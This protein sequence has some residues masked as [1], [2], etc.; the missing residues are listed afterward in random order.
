MMKNGEIDYLVFATSLHAS[1]IMDVATSPGI[2]FLEL[3]PKQMAMLMKDII[4]S[5]ETVIP[6][7]MYPGIEKDFHT[8]ARYYLIYAHK[9]MPEEL[10]YR[11]TRV[12]WDNV[13]EIRTVGAFGKYIK[14]ETAFKG[15][16]VPMHPGAVR[17]YKEI[18]MAP[19]K[20]AVPDIVRK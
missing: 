2:R 17:Y 5:T 11:I 18:G 10:V 4:G 7:D 9:D 15:M 16:T 1:M 6:K 19:P 8:I 12:V 20:P 14:L 13:N 3:G